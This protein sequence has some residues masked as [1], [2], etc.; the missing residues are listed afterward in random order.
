MSGQLT[1]ADLV[2]QLWTAARAQ[3]VTL[4]TFVKPLTSDP[5][6]WLGQL[7]EAHRPKPATL[8]RVAALIEGRDIPPPHNK[9]AVGYSTCTRAEREFRG[10]APS[11]R[12]VRDEKQI[13]VR[14]RDRDNLE[15]RR[16][17]AEAAA[18]ERLPGE[19]LHAA[20]RR[21]EHELL[22]A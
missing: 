6:K 13:E 21:I 4:G 11:S 10:L 3:G 16:A 2:H 8:E 12:Q 19:T 1:G 22:A 20:C 15:W 18:D 14:I 9:P 5:T 17:I 7:R